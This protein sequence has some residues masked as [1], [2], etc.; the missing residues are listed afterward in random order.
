M[1]VVIY[2]LCNKVLRKSICNEL[3]IPDYISV[4]GE[5]TAVVDAATLKE[6]EDYESKGYL[7]L[8]NK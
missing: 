7:K 5:T 1:N 8:R 2:W 3:T 4:N 6:L